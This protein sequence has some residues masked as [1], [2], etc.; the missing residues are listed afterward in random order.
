MNVGIWTDLTEEVNTF[1]DHDFSSDTPAEEK[2]LEECS[3]V[4]AVPVRHIL[5]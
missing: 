1:R 5:L 2:L 3:L 4:K